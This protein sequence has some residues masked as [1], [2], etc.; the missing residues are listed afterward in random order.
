[1]PSSPAAPGGG[2]N[3]GDAQE[4]QD[5]QEQLSE[6]ETELQRLSMHAVEPAMRESLM[7]KLRQV[8]MELFERQEELDGGVKRQ[9]FQAPPNRSKRRVQSAHFADHNRQDNRPT[10]LQNL[11]SES[12]APDYA[13]VLKKRSSSARPRSA[14]S[15]ASRRTFAPQAKRQEDAP[16]TQR[17]PIAMDMMKFVDH[18]RPSTASSRRSGDARLRLHNTSFSALPASRPGPGPA[19]YYPDYK[20]RATTKRAPAAS[21]SREG[22]IKHL[23]GETAPETEGRTG[24]GPK[25]KPSVVQTKKRHAVASIGRENRLGS[26]VAP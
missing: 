2:L 21:F 15:T 8:R 5:A 23:A 4:L 6:I 20:T 17:R 13:P 26:S 12:S 11:R 7:A 14:T 10:V 1:M 19:E 3:D 24:P 22:R 18:K 16:A 25:Y 9:F